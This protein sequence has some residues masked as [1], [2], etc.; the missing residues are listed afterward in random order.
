MLNEAHQ[1]RFITQR[2]LEKQNSTINTY[3]CS[4]MTP[5]KRHNTSGAL[6]IHSAYEYTGKSWKSYKFSIILES[7]KC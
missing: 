1:L 3:A 5:K 2:T 7:I 4:L 6:W